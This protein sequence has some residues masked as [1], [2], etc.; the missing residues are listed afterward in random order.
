MKKKMQSIKVI[1]NVIAKKLFARSPTNE[2]ESASLLY[3][4][5]N[6]N[7]SLLPIKAN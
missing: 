6:H 7:Q 5:V 3:V 2:Y 1:V 4:T